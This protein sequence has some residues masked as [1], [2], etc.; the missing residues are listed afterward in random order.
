[1]K[2]KDSGDLQEN[3]ELSMARGAG[4]GGVSGGGDRGELLMRAELVRMVAEGR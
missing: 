1:M 4:G 3:P 2:S